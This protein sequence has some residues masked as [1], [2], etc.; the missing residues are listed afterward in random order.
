MLNLLLLSHLTQCNI[1]DWDRFTRHSSGECSTETNSH[2]DT[3]SDCTLSFK[4]A[5]TKCPGV[6]ASHMGS[7]RRT[8][9][10]G[11]GGVLAASG[12]LVG[13]G[14]FNQFT[15]SRDAD[16]PITNDSNS[17]VALREGPGT[18]EIIQETDG[19]LV[20]DFTA[21]SNSEGIQSNTT[22]QVGG[23]DV[24][25]SQVQDP[26]DS[27][28][29]ANVS[30][31]PSPVGGSNA[32]DDPAI[33]VQNNSEDKLGVT[34][35]FTPDGNLNDER[36]FVVLHDRNSA[37]GGGGTDVHARLYG[38]GNDFQQGEVKTS[39]TPRYR[40]LFSGETV[41]ISLWFYTGQNPDLS[42]ELLFTARDADDVA[43]G[44]SQ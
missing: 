23:I 25:S 37:T 3:E 5:N 20:I 39:S 42:G 13:T 38:G 35:E 4:Q 1:T 17:L 28:S 12:A 43:V 16:I 24:G 36:I 41:G 8:V 7:S 33:V 2:S 19:Q 6:V 29:E 21:P 18:G 40:P 31:F 15:A 11:L 10:I 30:G 22:Y 27:D 9:L 32:K 26:L 14:A 44:D 34:V